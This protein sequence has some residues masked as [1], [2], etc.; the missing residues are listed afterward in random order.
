MPMHVSFWP[1]AILWG[2]RYRFTDRR[3]CAG[4]WK[5][6]RVAAHDTTRVADPSVSASLL[7][8]T[9]A[10]STYS[11]SPDRSRG[12]IPTLALPHL[13]E[14]M[15]RSVFSP[16]ALEFTAGPHQ[17]GG[18]PNGRIHLPPPASRVRTRF[19]GSRLQH[20][21]PYCTTCRPRPPGSALQRQI[22][23]L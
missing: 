19:P 15:P 14:G 6:L 18:G 8:P 17:G 21:R 3:R 16:A 7:N 9:R 5:T 13:R 11:Y 22:A 12:P 2:R 10:A 23:D 4:E 20:P 1:P